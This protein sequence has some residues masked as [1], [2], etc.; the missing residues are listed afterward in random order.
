[1]TAY[2]CLC[3]PSLSVTCTRLTDLQQ[4]IAYPAGVNLYLHRQGSTKPAVHLLEGR[5]PKR[6]FVQ[7]PCYS[8]LRVHLL[9]VMAASRQKQYTLTYIIAYFF[10][11]NNLQ[12]V[13]RTYFFGGKPV[14]PYVQR[15]CGEKIF[16]GHWRY[17]H[18][19]I[20]SSVFSYYSTRYL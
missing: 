18:V 14:N 3:K 8:Y 6:R 10:K 1:M 12:S 5:T 7:G 13:L 19:R 4:A 9:K 16:L 20:I 11:K 17:G 15:V 2:I